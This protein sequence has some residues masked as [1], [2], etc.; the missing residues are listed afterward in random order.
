[1]RAM[2]LE[3]AGQALRLVT[4]ETPAPSPSQIRVRVMACGICRTDL[5][6]VDNELPNLRYPII[7][8]HEIVGR[9]DAIGEGVTDR[10]IGERVGIPWLGD[11]CGHCRYCISGRENLCDDPKFTGYTLDGGYADYAIAG[12]SLAF[13]LPES[14]FRRRGRSASLCGLDRTPLT[15]DDGRCRSRDTGRKRSWRSYGR[16]MC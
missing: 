2:V 14:Y 6:V 4:R 5:H 15:K 7:P 16:L 8:G 13:A 11:T 9:I 10:H 12:A 1:M 3:G